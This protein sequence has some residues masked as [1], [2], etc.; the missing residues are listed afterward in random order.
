MNPS[1]IFQVNFNG[2]NFII[3]A[4]TVCEDLSDNRMK[5]YINNEEL[6]IIDW[7]LNMPIATFPLDKTGLISIE[8]IVNNL[9]K[10][11]YE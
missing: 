8:S 4:D 11:D 2:I 9:I 10:N 7:R 3:N 5:F 6:N 1:K